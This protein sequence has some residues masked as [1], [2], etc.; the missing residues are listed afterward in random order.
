MIDHV[1][2]EYCFVCWEEMHLCACWSTP[3]FLGGDLD[4]DL[5]GNLPDDPLQGQEPV[6]TKIRKPSVK[7]T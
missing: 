5:V 1:C 2:E 4:P 3:K 6:K 7:V